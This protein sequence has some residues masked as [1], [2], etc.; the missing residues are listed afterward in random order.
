MPYIDTA[1]GRLFYSDWDGDRADEHP[2]LVLIH[3]AGGTTLH[4][5]PHLRRLR[6]TDVHALDLPGHGHSPGPGLDTIAGY[7]DVVLA[8]ADALSLRSFVLTG[9]SMGGAI[10]QDFALRHPERLA[11][12]VLVGSG[13]RLRVHPDILQGVQQDFP[14]TAKLICDWALSASGSAKSRRQYLRRLLEVDPAV[15]LGDFQACDGFDVRERLGDI[16][17]PTL[18]I[19]GSEDR[20]TPPKYS[21]FLQEHIP[22]AELLLVEGAGHMVMLEQMQKVTEAIATFLARLNGA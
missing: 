15:L 3:G 10:A 20:L 1:S 13:A 11:G 16:S 8:W 9:H 21:R 12:L 2:P 14:A 17:L 6:Q 7:R 5:P 18:V 19:G 4:W 22:G